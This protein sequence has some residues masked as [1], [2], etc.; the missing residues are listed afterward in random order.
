MKTEITHFNEPYPNVGDVLTF[1]ASVA[2]T[3]S[4]AFK[5]SSRY[6]KQEDFSRRKSHD[7]EIIQEAITHLFTE[8]LSKEISEEFGEYFSQCVSFG[9]SNYLMLMKKIPMEGVA[10]EKLKDKLNQHLLV[11]TLASIIWKVG[12]YQINENKVPAFYFSKNPIVEL[13]KFY[14]S[15]G[16]APGQAL[17][18]CFEDNSRSLN[19]WKSGREIPNLQNT[20]R[21]A[22]WASQ[23]DKDQLVDDKIAFYLARLLAKL[24]EVSDYKYQNTFARA[25]A[26]RLKEKREP[27]FDLGLIFSLFYQKEID[28]LRPLS[29]QGLFIQHKLRRTSTKS[30]GDFDA[31]TRELDAFDE[32]VNKL[33]L[34]DQVGYFNEW[35]RGRLLILSGN[36]EGALAKYMSASEQAL[37]KNTDHLKKILNE[38]LAI[39]SM[40]KRQKVNMKQLKSRALTFSPEIIEPHLRVKDV[41]VDDIGLW[42]L[43]FV[44]LFP[45][46]GWFEEGYELHNQT[47]AMHDLSDLSNK[48]C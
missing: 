4:S 12:T 24:N 26:L 44:F 13:I 15:L 48:R 42:Q 18:D 41:T 47:L 20:M 43:S 33:Q 8:P 2:D 14:E 5:G 46:S 45:Q 23:S 22:C 9:L 10:P 3:K 16:A 7:P 38:G 37:Y 21:L 35:L 1:L 36:Y 17:T 25:V 29:K 34:V 40:Q 27:V 30:P 39:A 6:R 32:E 11:E 28:R 19:N 31:F